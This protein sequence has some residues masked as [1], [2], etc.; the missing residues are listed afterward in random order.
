[1]SVHSRLPPWLAPRAAYL[2]VP[3][4]AHNCGYCDFAVTAGQDHLIDLYVEAIAEELSRLMQD[5]Q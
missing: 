4:C 5:N 1:M 3:F 2:H